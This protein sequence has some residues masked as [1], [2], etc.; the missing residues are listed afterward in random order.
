MQEMASTTA[1]A[2][3]TPSAS[4]KEVP[5]LCMVC[6]DTPRF[7]DVSHLLTH[8]AS[9]SHLHHETQTKLRAHQDPTAS[10]ALQ[11]Y[12]NWY[13]DHGIEALLVGRLKA[14]QNKEA[15]KVRRERS[16]YSSLMPK[17]RIAYLVAAQATTELTETRHG[18]KQRW[19]ML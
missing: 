1:T 14:K 7:S 10:I 3:D 11:S 5:L 16:S 15:H 8:I 6:P 19:K 2:V 4:I 9:K 17:V 12:D 18:G 13:K